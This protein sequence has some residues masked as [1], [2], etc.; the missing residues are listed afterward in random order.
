M[1][2][3][4][5]I[6][7]HPDHA[8]IDAAV[9]SGEPNQRVAARYGV[10]ESS[11]RR[12]R[13]AGHIRDAVKQGHAE[14][15]LVTAEELRKIAQTGLVTLMDILKRARIRGD[16]KIALQAT[17]EL[18]EYVVFMEKIIG[19][20]ASGG[21]SL[22]DDPAWVEVREEVLEALYGAPRDSLANVRAVLEE[23]E[24]EA[25]VITG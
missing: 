15:R 24:E 9:V 12:H 14:F 7:S 21:S 8:A 19:G 17:R 13:D 23:E 22:R 20:S 18:R 3:V 4:C 1:P 2:R 5:T 10:T 16:D 11:I 6:C 25:G